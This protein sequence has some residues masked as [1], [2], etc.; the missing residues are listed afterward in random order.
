MTSTARFS[1]DDILSLTGGKLETNLPYDDIS[2]LYACISTDTRSI[3]SG[4]IYLPLKGETFDG[5][6]FVDTAIANG[7]G[8][9]IVNKSFEGKPSDDSFFVRVEDTLTAYHALATGWRDKINPMIVAVTGS[10]GKTTTKEMCAAVF[11]STLRTHKSAA[12]ENN[13]FG[14]PKTILAMPADTEVLVLEM[15][16]RGIGQIELLAQTS[17]PNVGII[18]Y[19]GTAHIEL[20]GSE[21]SIAIAKSEIL[22]HLTEN[23]IAIIGSPSQLLMKCVR[24]VYDGN[25]LTFEAA[26]IKDEK[27]SEEGTKFRV[28][29]DPTEYFVATHG[30]HH[31]QDAW[32]AI[33][34]GLHC[35]L[36]PEE[37]AEGL[38]DYRQV[39]GRGNVLTTADGAIIV[40]ESY[41]ANPDSVKC[42]VDGV[43]DNRAFPQKKK[44]VVLGEMAELG[45]VSEEL[46]K[47]LGFWMKE[48]PISLLVTVGDKAAKIGEAAS[49][50]TF[51][52]VSCKD[53]AE[54][55]DT[56][57]SEITNDSCVMVKGSNCARLYDLVDQLIEEK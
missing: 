15:A 8:G 35:G 47:E 9:C 55:F 11:S 56:V 44:I 31:V 10:S 14:V 27:V 30:V 19:A 13:E 6:N 57:A 22:K 54:A 5:H 1:I 52:I 39:K 41:N 53:I 17:K 46:H 21:E 4:D 32:C 49:G 43:I 25:M 48:K 24:D 18:T 29:D 28:G 12:N 38:A 36:T 42:A 33:M 20:L 34:A 37:V 7:A 50:A 40:D 3:E 51:S 2:D 45:A 16:M 26:N 23:G